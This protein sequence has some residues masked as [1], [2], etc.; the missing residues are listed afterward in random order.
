NKP[1]YELIGSKKPITSK[2]YSGMIYMDDL[3]PKENPAGIDKV[4]ENCQFDYG[5]GYRQ[6]KLKIGRGNMWM[7]K[8]K[9]LARDIEV[10]KMVAK[11]FPDCEILVD[12]NDGYT[13][14]DTI[15]YV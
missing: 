4:M 2:I 8:E 10:T 9:G 1:V 11:N 7:P 12:A 3:E 13:I 15:A 6:F 5:Y 14:E